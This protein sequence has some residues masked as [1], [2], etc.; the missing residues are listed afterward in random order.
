MRDKILVELYNDKMYKLYAKKL[1]ANLADEMISELMLAMCSLDESRLIELHGRGEL[2]Y[3]AMACL[4]N[5]VTNKYS[6]FKKMFNNDNLEIFHDVL[7]DTDDECNEMDYNDVD[8][9]LED[10]REFLD[11]RTDNVD[12][13][14]FD[15]VLY[16]LYF[17][18]GKSFRQIAK[19]TSI[20]TSAIYNSVKETQRLINDKFKTRYDGIGSE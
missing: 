9:L 10:I 8:D 2:K 12:G 17:N 11:D 7:E 14:W 16:S 3:Y 19:E 15:E 18:E 5:M 13:T 20:P 6:P 4:R 1:S